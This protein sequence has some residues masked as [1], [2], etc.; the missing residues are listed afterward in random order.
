MGHKKPTLTF[1]IVAGFK[2]TQL[3]W[4]LRKSVHFDRTV[5]NHHNPA[6]DPTAIKQTSCNTRCY[7]CYMVIYLHPKFCKSPH[8][9]PR[10]IQECQMLHTLQG[11]LPLYTVLLTVLKLI[12]RHHQGR[13]DVTHITWSSFSIHISPGAPT[14]DKQQR[15]QCHLL[16]QQGHLLPSIKRYSQTLH[17]THTKW[18]PT[19]EHNSFTNPKADKDTSWNAKCHIHYMN[20]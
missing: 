19:S 7:T 11:H 4:H 16:P 8:S 5:Q 2:D 12:K 13:Q 9:L 10:D 17:V 1:C 3:L 14:A 18:S 20:V 15:S 6:T